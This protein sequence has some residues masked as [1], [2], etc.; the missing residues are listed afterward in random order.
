[1]LTLFKNLQRLGGSGW[2]SGE[3]VVEDGKV[4]GFAS[5]SDPVDAVVDCGDAYL[6]PG[7]VDLHVH[8]N[9][10]GRT[11]W[12]GFATG[13]LAAAAGGITY[14]A[15]MPLNCI[16]STTTVEAFRAKLEAVA[17]L[18]RVDF[19]LWGGVVPGNAGALPALAAAGV[20]GFKA[21][22]SPSGTEEFGN[23]DLATLQEAMRQIAPTGLRLAL[24]AE[25]PVVL[26]PAAARLQHPSTPED[27]LASRP[28]EAEIRAVRIAAELSR[29]TG[30]P[31][32]I[33][34]VS[35]PEVLAV[36]H[37]AR[38][39]G[40]DIICETCP[41]YL[42]LSSE[43]A[44]A[45]GPAA[46]CAPPLRLR[47][48]RDALLNRLFAG[49]IDTIGSDHSP[50]PPELKSGR[51]F[52]DAWGGIAGIQHGLPLLIDRIG[53][54]DTKKLQALK[55]AFAETPARLVGC[56][57]KG[58]LAVGDDADFFLMTASP[59]ASEV[60]TGELLQRHGSSAYL[61]Q[62][63]QVCVVGTWL[64]GQPV[65]RDGEPAGTAKG[66]FI[67]GIAYEGGL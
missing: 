55:K 51:S 41:H 53:I 52:Y 64:R 3:L 36:I 7:A 17:P 31:I 59:Q 50:S 28:V 12:E 66:R 65:I 10:P 30:C 18:A 6:F 34:H 2:Q 13:T 47:A 45:I 49:E 14:V 57:A 29:S 43:D 39:G 9:E 11:H 32:T 33:V 35:A 20:M 54:K 16:P 26:G 19:G 1:M 24:H 40:V 42:L 46:K 56:P 48:T 4:A 5:G 58:C 44:A 21:F 25:D 62:R 22:M 38:A 60:P 67:P 63:R 37:E 23:S 61:G 15:D 8:F 27:W